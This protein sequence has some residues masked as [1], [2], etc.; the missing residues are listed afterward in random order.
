MSRAPQETAMLKMR[1]DDFVGRF[2]MCLLC[3]R[4]SVQ[5][6]RLY[7]G[8]VVIDE[9]AMPLTLVALPAHEPRTTE[10]T[11]ARVRCPASLAPLGP[12]EAT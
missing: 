7:A 9:H 3:R 5:Q 12:L 6:L 8:N 2:A 1:P 4:D 10:A 11:Y